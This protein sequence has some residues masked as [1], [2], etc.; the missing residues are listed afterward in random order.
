MSET[1]SSAAEGRASGTRGRIGPGTAEGVAWI[2]LY[3]LLA[4]LPLGAALFGQTP[5]YRGF[6]VEFGVAL[7][8]VALAMFGLQFALTARFRRLA[9]PYGLDAQLQFHR[10]AG[11][12]AFWLA[13]AHPV[14]LIVGQPAFAAFLDPRVEPIRALALWAVTGAL[15]L[16]VGLTLWRRPLGVS[17]PWWRVTHALLGVFVL[18]VGLVH[19]LRV[20][21]YL[22]VPWRQGLWVAMTA[23]AM[24]LLLYARV[25]RPIG[26]RRKRYT[27]TAVRPERGNSWTLVVE[28]VGHEGMA[29]DAGQ[30]A[31]LTLGP[32]PFVID[33]HPFSFASS[34][35][36]PA[37]LEFTIRALGD[38]TATIGDVRPGTT[39]FLEGPYGAFVLSP[40]AESAVFIVGGVGVTPAMSILRTL[41]DR[42]DRRPLVL[43][44]ANRTWDDV[45]F[46]EEL[47]ELEHELNLRVIHLLADPPAEWAGERGIP[48]GALLERCLPA[49]DP[50]IE[51]FVCGPEAMMDAVEPWLLRRGV[52][53][54]RINAERFDIA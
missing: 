10:Q 39:A 45:L 14:M 4:A 46:R 31:W 49:D 25:L 5:E 9:S 47:A 7:G 2:G 3:V 12:I 36:T 23:A 27:V 16:L 17:Y 19:V 11:L 32:S 52:P 34:A 21:H 33:Q 50:G 24:G 41:R 42:G 13:L 44:F 8:F 53:V 18:F 28:P 22:A 54:R 1:L 35:A 6:L 15:V 38:F 51:Y 29:F 26:M 37:R 48:D 20:R 40:H 43:V 30:F